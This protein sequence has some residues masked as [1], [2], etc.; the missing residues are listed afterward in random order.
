MCHVVAPG[1]RDGIFEICSIKTVALRVV[2]VFLDRGAQQVNQPCST[3]LDPIGGVVSIHPPMDE[4]C[5]PVAVRLH[6]QEAGVQRTVVFGR[7]TV[8]VLVGPL[9]KPLNARSVVHVVRDVHQPSV[10]GAFIEVEV[11]F[12]A[13]VIVPVSKQDFTCGRFEVGVHIKN[14]FQRTW[15]FV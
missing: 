7:P 14:C 8:N 4:P 2:S 1:I 6:F 3:R 12:V 9:A 13:D 10:R 11:V 5:K 15:Q